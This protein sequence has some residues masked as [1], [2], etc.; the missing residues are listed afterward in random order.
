MLSRWLGQQGVIFVIDSTDHDR[1][2]EA[3]DELH[4]IMKEDSLE[5]TLVL[6]L[7]NKQGACAVVRA[8]VYVCVC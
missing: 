8:C 4:R 6:V 2:S 7:A 5:N 1:L 3:R